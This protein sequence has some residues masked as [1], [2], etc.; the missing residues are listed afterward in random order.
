M[1]VE[2]PYN[3]PVFA[4][5]L[6]NLEIDCFVG[7]T[8]EVT[9]GQVS[10]WENELHGD[11]FCVSFLWSLDLCGWYAGFNKCKHS[12]FGS[13]CLVNSVYLISPDGESVRVVE[14]GLLDAADVN[15]FCA[16]RNCWSSSFLCRTPSAFQCTMLSV[17]WPVA[18]LC[19]PPAI[20]KGSEPQSVAL[21]GPFWGWGP[22]AV[23]PW[24]R[25]TR[26][27]PQRSK[28]NCTTMLSLIRR[29]P[30]FYPRQVGCVI[31]FRRLRFFT[32]G[33]LLPKD[34]CFTELAGPSY[35]GLCSAFPSHRRFVF[36]DLRAPPAQLL[37]PAAGC[38]P[39]PPSQLLG[40]ASSSTW[41]AFGVGLFNL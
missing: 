34:S 41:S 40:A 11:V 20:R 33:G 39:L 18:L 36:Q 25:P 29:Q 27:T 19:P 1:A 26:T 31:R 2:V 37:W 5:W 15:F 4:V 9:D 7:W 12:T 21:V 24:L 35:P 22:G 13:V 14:T 8:V 23:P 32:Q 10:V 30:I 17:W 16:L 3:H 6:K 28:D 38:F